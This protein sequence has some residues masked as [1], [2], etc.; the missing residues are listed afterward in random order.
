MKEIDMAPQLSVVVVTYQS[1]DDIVDC[2]R[3]VLHSKVRCELIVVDNASTDSTAERTTAMIGR[4]PHCRLVCNTENVGFAKAVNQGVSLTSAPYIL[5]L[6]PDC[7]LEADTL[8]LALAALEHN[9]GA[10]AAGCM[11]LNEDGSEQAGARRCLPTPWRS[12]VRVLLLHKL[13]PANQRFSGFLLNDQPLPSAP[14]AVE[15]T[16]GAFMLVRREVVE[17][18]GGLD[19]GYF[20]HCEDLDWCV[21]MRQAGWQV[22]FVPA[23]RALHKKGRS[24]RAR[25]IRVEFYKHV[26]MV[27]FYRKFFRQRYPAVLMGAVVAAVWVRFAVKVCVMLPALAWTRAGAQ[28]GGAAIAPASASLRHGQATQRTLP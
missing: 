21:R 20:M 18:V 16:S 2:I 1:Q 24:S 3:S 27:R 8:S 7:I 23:A 25:P 14:M 11:L 4:R 13:F 10:G 17:Q 15:A 22:L 9:P 19:E 26:G 6:N 12:L 28:L 5:L